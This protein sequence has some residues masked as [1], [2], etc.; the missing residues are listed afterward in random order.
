MATDGG[1][2]SEL[3]DRLASAE[4]AHLAYYGVVKHQQMRPSRFTCL[5]SLPS[6]LVKTIACNADI[7][8][9]WRHCAGEPAMG[10]C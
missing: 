6:E 10:I 3:T 4:Q 1:L 7:D 9:C 2:P 5:G 8:F